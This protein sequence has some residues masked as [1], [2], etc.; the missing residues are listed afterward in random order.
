M[1]GSTISTT[2]ATAVVGGVLMASWGS[3]DGSTSEFGIDSV[4]ST[5]KATALY[6]GL[7]FDGGV[8]YLKKIFDTVKL[9]FSPLVSG[10]SISVK[11]KS[12]KAIAGG[13][14]SAGA[15]WKYAV[16]GSGATTFSDADETEAIFTIGT[17]ANVYEVGLEL[18]PTGND[19]PE[20]LSIT[21]YLSNENYE[22]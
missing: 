20:I 11:Y 2:A 10:T 5:T 4:S 19:S 13:D 9:T 17:S 22:F 7:E 12:D 16:L 18:N 21:T 3:T 6:E 8:P 1:L 14:S 15:G